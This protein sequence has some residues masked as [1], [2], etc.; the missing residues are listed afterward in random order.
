MKP[1][2]TRPEQRTMV[3][4]RAVAEGMDCDIYWDEDTQTVSIWEKEK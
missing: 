3:P 2:N 1:N 4:V